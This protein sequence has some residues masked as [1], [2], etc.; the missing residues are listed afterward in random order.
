[1]RGVSLR[2]IVIAAGGTGGHLSPAEA[3]AT[4]LSARGHWVVLMTDARSV[5]RTE[6]FPAQD[7]VV[8]PG[9]GVAGRGGA[10]RLRAVAGITAGVVVARDRL[11]KL[12]PAVVIGFGGYPSVAP[13]LATRLVRPRP[14][15]LLHEQNGILG[16]ANRALVRH[17][18]LLALSLPGTERVP[19]GTPTLLSGNPVRASFVRAP[20]AAGEPRLLVLGGSLGARVFADIVPPALAALPQ[21]LRLRLTVDQ[22]CRPEDVLRTRDAYVAA[23]IHAEIAPFFPDVSAR[24]ALATLVISRAGASSVAELTAVGRAAFLVPLPGAID[25][26]QTANARVLATAGAAELL[27]QA[28]LTPALL[29]ARI[30]AMLTD[31]DG[32][33]AAAQAAAGLAFPDAADD[34]ADAA[35][36]LAAA[37]ARA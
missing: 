1:M 26:H 18:R 16:R 29:A 32:L 36:A 35:L 25:D 2:P 17:A 9:A 33:A 10:A 23:G 4:V 14:P 22:Q 30:G 27:T 11:M 31:P 5:A 13:V 7:R 8:L 37:E 20:L 28:T 34:I 12:R 6:A 24:M 19:A 15:V 21:A 3:V